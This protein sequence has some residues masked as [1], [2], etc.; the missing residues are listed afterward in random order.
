MM[1]STLP[2][3]F[4]QNRQYRI[5]ILHAYYHLLISFHD[6]NKKNVVIEK[7]KNENL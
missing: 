3:N 4:E 6:Y 1:R 2:Q 5:I 7:V